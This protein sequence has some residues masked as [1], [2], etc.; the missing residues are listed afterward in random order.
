MAFGELLSLLHGFIG[1][2][3]IA[4]APWAAAELFAL[5]SNDGVK[6]L[7]TVTLGLVVIS[8]VGCIFLAAPTY[9]VYYPSAKSALLN[10]PKPW[11]HEVLMEVKEHIGL[12]EP[13]L[14]F[15]IAFLIWYYADDLLDDKKTNNTSSPF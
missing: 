4:G 2:L 6:R 1:I 7:K 12:L 10:G 13:R 14:M 5:G 15:S 11:V 8:F 3:L 9:L